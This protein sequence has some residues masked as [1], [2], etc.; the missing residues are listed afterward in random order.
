MKALGK[1][2]PPT[3][4]RSASW[5]EWE[6]GRAARRKLSQE[7]SGGKILRRKQGDPRKDRLLRTLNSGERGLPFQG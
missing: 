5:A 3:L 4:P 1:A 2:D 7:L 6:S